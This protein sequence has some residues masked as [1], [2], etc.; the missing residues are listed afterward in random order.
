MSLNNPKRKLIKN[1]KYDY[2]NSTHTRLYNELLS[3]YIRNNIYK[4]TIEDLLSC[5]FS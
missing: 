3:E 4:I 1:N 5:I 2:D